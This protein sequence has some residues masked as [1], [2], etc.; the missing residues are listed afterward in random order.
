SYALTV[1]TPC[2]SRQDWTGTWYGVPVV[3]PAAA[4]RDIKPRQSTVW[5]TLVAVD[6]ARWV[7]DLRH[8]DLL[9]HRLRYRVP[10]QDAVR[11]PGRWAAILVPNA[12]E[13]DPERVQQH[14]RRASQ[15]LGWAERWVPVRADDPGT[16]VRTLL[17]PTTIRFDHTHRV[18]Y[19]T[20]PAERQ[21]WV[22]VAQRWLPDW[23]IMES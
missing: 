12:A 23:A 16:L 5:G 6:G 14:I 11:L 21:T 10:F 2:P 19:C 7:F 4:H 17:S 9:T 8:P 20:V 3:I 1:D 18:V 22:P 13:S 15:S